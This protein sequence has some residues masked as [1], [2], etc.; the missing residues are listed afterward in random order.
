[1][2]LQQCRR[3]FVMNR[4]NHTGRLRIVH[5][6]LQ[7]PFWF[8]TILY[9]LF[10]VWIIFLDPKPSSLAQL[11]SLIVLQGQNLTLGNSSTLYILKLDRLLFMLIVSIILTK[12]TLIWVHA[13]QILQIV[14]I[15][16]TLEWIIQVLTRLF[17]ICLIIIHNFWCNL[18][19]AMHFSHLRF[20]ISLKVLVTH[21][22]LLLW[23][24]GL[25]CKGVHRHGGGSVSTATRSIP[26]KVIINSVD[27]SALSL[28]LLP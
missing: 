7:L 4:I 20:K 12:S 22:G 10:L 17:L 28:Y 19:N 3:N 27:V 21:S 14:P 6:I 5:S 13:L 26:W 8:L 25:V 24:V 1:M 16:A 11:S 18:N 2:S 23:S 15:L 9:F